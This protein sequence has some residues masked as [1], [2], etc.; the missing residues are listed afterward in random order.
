MLRRDRSVLLVDPTPDI[1]TLW[2]LLLSTNGD[3][4]PF[5]EASD[6]RDALEKLGRFPADVVLADGSVTDGPGAQFVDAVRARRPHAVVVVS[7]NAGECDDR[8]EAAHRGTDAF[9]GKHQSATERLP[10]LLEEV[11]DRPA[12]VN[13]DPVVTES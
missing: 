2:R 8:E 1:R 9:V 5:A 3:F 7:T 12:S 4:G 13:G 6:A 11:L 10:C